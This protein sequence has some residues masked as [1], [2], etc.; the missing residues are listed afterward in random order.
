MTNRPNNPIPRSSPVAGSGVETMFTVPEP[1]GS[2]LFMAEVILKEPGNRFNV[3]AVPLYSWAPYKLTVAFPKIRSNPP[4]FEVGK[5]STPVRLAVVA[6]NPLFRKYEKLEN[7]WVTKPPKT[8]SSVASVTGF[9]KL[10]ENDQGS[11]A[12]L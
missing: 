9:D 7:C 10:K 11:P 2:V 4:R 1:V 12:A 8:V 3:G 5:N 6:T